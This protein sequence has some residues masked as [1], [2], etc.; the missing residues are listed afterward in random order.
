M[1]PRAAQPDDLD[2]GRGASTA[3]RAMPAMDSV[4]AEGQLQG[5][6]GSDDSALGRPG[7]TLRPA[8]SL[9][10]AS[11]VHGGPRPGPPANARAARRTREPGRRRAGATRRRATRDSESQECFIRGTPSRRS[12]S[13]EG[14]GVAGVF[15]QR[16]SE[17]QECFTPLARDPRLSPET[18][19]S[20]R[21]PRQ[22]L[23][24]LLPPSCRRLAALGWTWWSA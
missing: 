15:N 24:P 19:A 21:V 10:G 2:T 16:D 3:H 22:A 12:V 20:R 7:E 6:V 13:S 18:F 14:L 11:N 4:A 23:S 8:R 1:G 17:S 9:R 5:L